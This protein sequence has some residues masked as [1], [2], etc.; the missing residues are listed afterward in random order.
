MGI[1][2]WEL[3]AVRGIREATGDED[4][5]DSRIYRQ[6]ITMKPIS[7]LL[8]SKT[9]DRNHPRF[10]V[11]FDDGMTIILETTKGELVYENMLSVGV[12]SY[13]LKK[14]KWP[15]GKN[16]K[17]R[18]EMSIEFIENNIKNNRYKELKKKWVSRKT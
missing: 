9:S 2:S 15:S 8:N 13:Y 3:E 18:V 10:A 7:S 11:H 4:L 12:G 6:Y 14:G 17:T 16:L 5:K 1:F